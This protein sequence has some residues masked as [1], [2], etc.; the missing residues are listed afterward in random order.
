MYPNDIG[1]TYVTPDTTDKLNNPSH[2][3]RHQAEASEIQALK[4]KVGIDGSADT[5]SLDFHK[6]STTNPHSVT[7]SQVGLGNCDN[8]SDAT[9]LAAT[10]LAV[11]PV[12]SIYTSI[13]STDPG[14]LFGGTWSAFGSGKVLVGLDS[15]D[16]DFDTPEETGGE[17]THLLT[18]GESG[19]PAHTHALGAS[20]AGS[21]HA[22][23]AASGTSGHWAFDSDYTRTTSGNN[24]AADAASAHNNIQPYI[25]VYFFKRT[26]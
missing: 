15:T 23:Q 22:V 11:Y 20:M 12:G 19:V 16:A 5:D 13:V 9:K 4:E 8:T 26:A 24:T 18:S 6:N 1:E 25:T 7:K 14:T 17:K 3:A 2:T 10:L 21:D